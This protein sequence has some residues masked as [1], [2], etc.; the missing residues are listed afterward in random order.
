MLNN[1]IANLSRYLVS[2]QIITVEDEEEIHQTTSNKA[3][4]FLCKLESVLKINIYGTFYTTLD[5]MQQYGNLADK[6]V[7]KQL[8]RNIDELK[9]GE[10]VYIQM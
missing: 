9:S 7:A 5:I 6:S 8:K 4:V 1:S 3:R 2:K 10:P